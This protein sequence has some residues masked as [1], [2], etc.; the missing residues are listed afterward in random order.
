MQNTHQNMN[1]VLLGLL[2]RVKANDETEQSLAAPRVAGLHVEVA[3]QTREHIVDG[4]LELRPRLV[5]LLDDGDQ[6]A[7]GDHRNA[8]GGNDIVHECGLVRRREREREKRH[9]RWRARARDV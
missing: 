9:A 6:R 1:C 7:L 8:V 5:V 4:Q 3:L 2:E